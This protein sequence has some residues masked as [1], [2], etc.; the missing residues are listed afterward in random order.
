MSSKGLNINFQNMKWHYFSHFQASDQKTSFPQRFSFDPRGSKL[1]FK[2]GNGI[3][4]SGIGIISPPSRPLIKK[5]I[6]QNVSHLSQR[7][8]N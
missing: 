6:L 3:I 7:I 4:Q 8:Q 2:T 1:I 5:L